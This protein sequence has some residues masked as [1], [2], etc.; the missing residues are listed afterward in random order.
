MKNIFP[1]VCMALLVLSCKKSGKN[2]PEPEI[3][4]GK[5]AL[6]SPA[7]AV[8]LEG[9]VV[10]DNI[11]T[12]NFS[13]T[14]AKNADSYE[15]VIKNLKTG[16]EISKPTVSTELAVNLDRNTPYSWYVVSKSASSTQTASSDIRKF[17]SAATEAV[18]YAPFPADN[19]Q[20]ETGG[21]ISTANGKITLSWVG[22]DADNDIKD[23]D[24][25]FG[26]SL[27]TLQVLKS[28]HTGNSITDVPVT[29]G[30]T[31]YWKVLVR[32]SKNNTSVSTVHNFKV[33]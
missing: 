1:L 3:I 12:I 15:V 26:T 28:G 18:S 16:D 25:Y 14:S 31:Y 24:I 20:P 11:S 5:A 27:Q 17:Y 32:D 33:N 8:C 7:A 13:W 2:Q 21:N 9:V 4:P 29:P 10:S 6:V 30:T 23:Y 19:L 22:E